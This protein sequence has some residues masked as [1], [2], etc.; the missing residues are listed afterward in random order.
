MAP[1]TT[2]NHTWAL[3]LAAPLPEAVELAAVPVL[4]LLPV[5]ARPLFLVVVAVDV[6]ADLLAV[7]PPRGAVDWP[8]IWDWIVELNDP[9]MLVNLSWT[10]QTAATRYRKSTYANFAEKACAGYCVLVLSFRLRE[11]TRMKLRERVIRMHVSGLPVYALVVIVR[12]YAS[13]NSKLDGGGRAEVDIGRNDVQFRL[14][15]IR[16]TNNT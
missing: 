11:S 2:L 14:I 1:N 5:A 7:A 12:S 15:Q 8:S 10:C 6:D 13:V 3:L 16:T 9:F 4:V